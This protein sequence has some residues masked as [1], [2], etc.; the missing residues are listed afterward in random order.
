MNVKGFFIN[1]EP[2]AIPPTVDPATGK[3]VSDEHLTTVT[4]HDGRMRRRHK[5]QRHQSHGERRVESA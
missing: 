5:V 4:A 2:S 3:I 1:S